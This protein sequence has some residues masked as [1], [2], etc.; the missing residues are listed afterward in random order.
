MKIYYSALYLKN[1]KY[2]ILCCV[3][4]KRST[5]FNLPSWIKVHKVEYFFGSVLLAY[6]VSSFCF[7]R[8]APKKSH[9]LAS[10]CVV[11]H[12]ETFN[13]LW[14]VL[15]HTGLN[16]K[17]LAETF[18]RG[19][20]KSLASRPHL[21]STC[22]RRFYANIIANAQRTRRRRRL[23]KRR[24]L[25]GVFRSDA[26]IFH[27]RQIAM[28]SRVCTWILTAIKCR[29][30]FASEASRVSHPFWMPEWHFALLGIIL[31]HTHILLEE[32]KENQFWISIRAHQPEAKSIRVGC[33]RHFCSSACLQF[34]YF[35]YFSTP[36]LSLQRSLC[37]HWESIGRETGRHNTTQARWP[38]V[39]EKQQRDGRDK[40]NSRVNT[41]RES[42]LGIAH[43]GKCGERNTS[44]VIYTTFLLRWPTNK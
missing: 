10:S 17:P 37:V 38:L 20:I 6:G 43:A 27:P 36:A 40:H 39:K 4:L 8:K 12:N 16:L 5:H 9:P 13:S 25:N 3:E 11:K 24:E 30:T 19:A 29:E 35:I 21:S 7:C 1:V 31:I 15:F 34:L 32:E 41:K 28:R 2:N 22:S 23:L 42:Y 26:L 18:I 44:G 14:W 33:I